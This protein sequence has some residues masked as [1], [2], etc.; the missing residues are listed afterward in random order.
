MG[1]VLFNSIIKKIICACLVLVCTFGV[2]SQDSS[3][4]E[5]YVIGEVVT[6]DESSNSLIAEEPSDTST[7]WAFVRMIL[8]LILVVA[9]IY[10]IVYFLKKGMG[11]KTID[12][13]FLKRAA[14]LSVG[15]G[16]SIQVITLVDKAW[17]VGVSEAGIQTIGE[18]TDPDLVT[19]MV[20]EAE[21]QP[22]SSKPRDFASILNTFSVTAKATE[23]TLKQQR[24]RLRNGGMNE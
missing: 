24:E 10:A 12:Q 8:A 14:T 23:K 9:V 17:L 3:N 5:D 18:I 22:T 20:L 21:K 16:K 7:V 6:N 13:P 11:I 15:P 19:Q 4:E 1:G 2:Y